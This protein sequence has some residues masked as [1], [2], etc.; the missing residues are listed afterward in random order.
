MTDTENLGSFAASRL[1]GAA[2]LAAFSLT[3]WDTHRAQQAVL[4]G[5]LTNLERL[6]L[7][8]RRDLGE[9]WGKTLVLAMTEFGRT[10]RENGNLGTDHGTGGAMVMA[11]GALRGGK[12]YGDWPGLEEA[13]LYQRRDLMPTTDVRAW[14]AWAMRGLYGLDRG[15]LE[16]AVFPGLDMGR[17][18]GILR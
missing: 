5:S 6:I 13:A 3:G 8:L 15:L 4:G 9:V 12:V 18:P 10:A 11:G 1:R 2:R 7:R 16:D 17:D 14:A